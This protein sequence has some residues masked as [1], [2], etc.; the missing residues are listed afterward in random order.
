MGGFRDPC[1]GFGG[2]CDRKKTAD[3]P[4]HGGTLARIALQ[5]NR[6]LR[7]PAQWQEFSGA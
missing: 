7:N 4:S 3:N 5:H 1:A 2:C 6:G